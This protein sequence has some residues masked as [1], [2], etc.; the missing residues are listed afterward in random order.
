MVFL[1]M[2]ESCMKSG[3]TAALN[4]NLRNT[5]D[6]LPGCY[7]ATRTSTCRLPVFS[8]L[9]GLMLRVLRHIPQLEPSKRQEQISAHR[10][11]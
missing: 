8:N 1:M 4:N 11:L 9:T 5:H 3:N 10:L 6:S 7:V 2:S